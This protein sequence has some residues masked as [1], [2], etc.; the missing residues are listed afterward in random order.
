ASQRFLTSM[1]RELASY[2]PTLH[3]YLQAAGHLM[4]LS[5]RL[6]VESGIRGYETHLEW[7]R[8]ALSTYA[9]QK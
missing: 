2:I 4:P 7:A 6:A 5:A 9:K 1:E 3:A 8:G